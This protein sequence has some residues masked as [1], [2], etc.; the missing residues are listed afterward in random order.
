MSIYLRKIL[1][2]SFLFFL[3][4]A[5]P[6]ASAQEPDDPS[7]FDPAVPIDGGLSLLLA[8]GAVYGGRRVMFSLR[9]ERG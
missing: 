3:L 2:Y 5:S 6:D 9:Q 4:C 7:P 8:A 1:S